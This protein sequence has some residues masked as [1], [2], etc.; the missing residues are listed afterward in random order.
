LPSIRSSGHV[1]TRG[2]IEAREAVSRAIVVAFAVGDAA[3]EVIMDISAALLRVG[4]LGM[5]D[6]IALQSSRCG[7]C[8]TSSFQIGSSAMPATRHVAQDIWS[9]IQVDSFPI[10]RQDRHSLSPAYER[11][12][13]HDEATDRWWQ[14]KLPSCTSLTAKG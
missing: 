8:W 1:V 7:S 3:V 14:L 5:L 9:A 13:M 12:Q 6:E 11:Q 4:L 2:A 10:S